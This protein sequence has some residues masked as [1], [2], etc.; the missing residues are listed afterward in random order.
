MRETDELQSKFVLS[1]TKL[2]F[3]IVKI[4]H[5]FQVEI[6]DRKGQQIPV[7]WAVDKDG[8]PTTD[9]KT[10][11]GLSPLGGAENTCMNSNFFM[12][13]ILHYS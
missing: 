7:G 1:G 10:V 12:K 13:R 2:D 3:T 5:L 8:Q 11:T 4:L 6:A 9:P